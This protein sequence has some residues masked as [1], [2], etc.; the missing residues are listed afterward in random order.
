MVLKAFIIFIW[1]YGFRE[2]RVLPS[3]LGNV[4]VDR[5]DDW[6]I[7]MRAH[8]LNHKQ[9]TDETRNSVSLLNS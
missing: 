9:E 1:S 7:K 4:A 6:G 2:L 5:H 8:S 3:W